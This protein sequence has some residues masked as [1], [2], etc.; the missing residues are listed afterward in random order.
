MASIASVYVDVVPSTASIAD[1]IKR[2]LLGAD[3]DV[4]KAAKRWAREIEHELD[5]ADATVDVDADTKAAEKKIQKLEKDRHTAHVRVEVDEASLARAKTKVSGALGGI[6][7][8]EALTAAVGLAPNV[9]PLIGSAVQAVG[10]LSG[11][12]GL[13]PAAA[14]AAGLAMGSL[15]IATMGFGDAVKAVGDPEKFAEALPLSW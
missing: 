15:K 10:Q 3:S 5:K 9:V 11:V 8:G 6:A 2:P 4:R 7:K 13:I 12:L 14:G 1:G